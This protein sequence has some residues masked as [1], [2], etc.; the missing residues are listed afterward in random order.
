MPTGQKERQEADRE[1]ADERWHE[2]TLVFAS[3]VGTEQN[4]RSIS[5]MFR[6]VLDKAGLVGK[7]WT[8]PRNAPQLRAVRQRRTATRILNGASLLARLAWKGRT[9]PPGRR[10][11]YGARPPADHEPLRWPMG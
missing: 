2:T 7:E 11:T 6:E 5:R 8:P 9:R 1:K 4:P 3:A 10:R